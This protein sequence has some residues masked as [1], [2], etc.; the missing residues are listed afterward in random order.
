MRCQTPQLLRADD[1]ATLKALAAQFTRGGTEAL[2]NPHIFE[3]PE[4]VR[5]G[6]LHA[7]G[8]VGKPAD[9]LRETKE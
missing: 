4:V 5:A 7:L 1:P 8:A 9:L 2:E 3:T 6:G